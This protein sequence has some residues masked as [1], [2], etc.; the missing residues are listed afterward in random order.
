M[1]RERGGGGGGSRRHRFTPLRH[2]ERD[3]TEQILTDAVIAMSLREGHSTLHTTRNSSSIAAGIPQRRSPRGNSTM[4]ED[5][6]P[7]VRYVVPERIEDESE[8]Y[9]RELQEKEEAYARELQEKELR[10]PAQIKEDENLAKAIAMV[11]EDM[12]ATVVPPI[13]QKKKRRRSSLFRSLFRRLRAPLSRRRREKF[14]KKIET[15]LSEGSGPPPPPVRI[16]SL[17]HSC[18]L[19]YHLSN[20]YE[21]SHHANPPYPLQHWSDDHHHLHHHLYIGILLHSHHAS[22]KINRSNSLVLSRSVSIVN[23]PSLV[24]S[25]SRPTKI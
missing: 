9:A 13:K 3:V 24:I 8:A 2:D 16:V 6:P 1:R 18:T 15:S 21:L 23:L 10:E 12:V 7:P 11:Q 25:I 4:E 22:R 17:A 20:R 14:M 19:T 5:L